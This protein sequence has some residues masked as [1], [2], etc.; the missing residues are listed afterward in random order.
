MDIEK[1]LN[2]LWWGSKSRDNRRIHWTNWGNLCAPKSQGGLSFKLIREF[3]IALLGKQAWRLITSPNSLVAKIFKARYYVNYSFMEVSI[4]HDPSYCWRSIMASQE[5]IKKG[6]ARR[7][8]NGRTTSIWNDNWVA[9]QGHRKLLTPVIEIL[10]E[11]FNSRDKECIMK[12]PISPD[13]EDDWYWS[14]DIKGN[15]SVK[16]AYRTLVKPPNPDRISDDKHWVVLWKLKI[17][18]KMKIHW[19]R[20][21]KGIIPVRE[22][23][24]RRGVELDSTCPLCAIHPESIKHLFLDCNRT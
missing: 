6:C 5:L 10:D 11:L 14:F 23:L 7:I 12:T 3:N 18:K 9:D 22:V 19:W 2:R 8:G 17:P 20:I 16:S 15:Y 1:C 24:R 13:Y 4:G 21:I